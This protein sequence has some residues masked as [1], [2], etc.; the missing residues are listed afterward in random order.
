[1]TAKACQFASRPVIL[2]A[3]MIK[4]RVIIE[5]G[6]RP[7]NGYAVHIGNGLK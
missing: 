4:V 1:M 3:G 5:T 2:R 6:T 7:S